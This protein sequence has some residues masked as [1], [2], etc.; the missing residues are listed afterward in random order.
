MD[1]EDHSAGQPADH[2]L[3]FLLVKYRGEFTYEGRS[4]R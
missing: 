4:F 3:V 1:G 2:E